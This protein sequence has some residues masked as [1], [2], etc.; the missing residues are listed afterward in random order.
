MQD[1]AQ[2]LSKRPWMMHKVMQLLQSRQADL[3]VRTGDHAHPLYEG[4]PRPHP[5]NWPCMQPQEGYTLRLH[6][7]TC[8]HRACDSSR[9]ADG[10]HLC[11]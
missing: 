5:P 2:E 7:V 3:W 10:S 11:Q 8:I 6:C 9:Q 1:T 4:Y